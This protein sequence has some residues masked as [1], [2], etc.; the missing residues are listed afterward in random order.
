MSRQSARAARLAS[1]ENWP[2]WPGDEHIEASEQFLFAI[3]KMRAHRLD[4]QAAAIALNPVIAHN[5][6]TWDWS[7]AWDRVLD[8]LLERLPQG[9]V[10]LPLAKYLTVRLVECCPDMTRLPQVAGL[11]RLM[12]AGDDIGKREIGRPTAL[13]HAAR[14]YC[15]YRRLGVA[16]SARELARHAKV[17]HTLA[18]R[19]VSQWDRDEFIWR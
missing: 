2:A 15:H 19:W 18:A 5:P 14:Y 9:T 7:A 1:A 4:W 10:P 11:V 13:V 3:Y 6:E 12:L 17:S 8:Q 16:V